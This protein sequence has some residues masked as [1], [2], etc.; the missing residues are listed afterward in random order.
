MSGISV[1]VVIDGIRF[2]APIEEGVP[3]RLGSGHGVDVHLPSG[4]YPEH[5]TVMIDGDDLT[6]QVGEHLMRGPIQDGAL[7]FESAAQLV[8]AA[9]APRSGRSVFDL[10]GLDEFVI[11]AH[12][13]A[14]VHSADPGLALSAVRSSEGGW[15]VSVTGPG[16]FVSN[17]HCPEGR[18]QLRNG[19]HLGAGVHDLVLFERE[20]HV[21]DAIVAGAALPRRGSSTTTPPA[22]YPDLRRSPRLI[23]RDPEE[24][25]TVNPPPAEEE[26][27]K[28]GQLAKLIIPPLLMVAVTAVMAVMRGNLLFVLASATT[29]VATLT[30]SLTGYIKE[31]RTSAEKREAADA[32]YREYLDRKA[33]EIHS[34]NERQRGGALYHF[35][36]IASLLTL[37]E[38]FSPRVFE[39]TALQFDFL[40]Y[41]LGLGTVKSTSQIDFPDQERTSKNSEL[42]ALVRDLADSSGDLTGMPI[43]ADLMHGPVG[44]VGPRRLVVEQ[45]QLLVNQLAVFHSYHDVQ[46]VMV[47]PEDELDDWSWMRW[48]RHSSLQEMNLRGFVYDQ[49]SRD[50]VLSSL[51]Q[52]L[53]ARQNALNE[54]RA[55]QSTSFSPH[56]V[57]VI[58]DEALV[59]DHVIMEFLRE[60][61]TSLGCSVVFVQETM[62]SLSD[63]ITTV[64]DVRDRDTAVLVLERGE[65]REARITLDHFPERFDKERLPRA[66]GARDHLQNLKSSIPDSV[67]FLEMYEVERFEDLGV[68]GRWAANSPHRTLGV[69]LGL[70]GA[71]DI[72]KLDLHEKA[73]GPHGLVAG[74]TGSGKSE[75]I[76]SYI[77][78]LAVN[79]HPHD[80][81]FLL[82]DYKGGGMANLFTDLPHLLGTITN[83][84]GAQSMRAL[85][86]INAELKR[87]QRLFSANNVNHINQY[88]KLYKSG[89]V[90]EPM[91]HLF[92]ISDEFA[93]L[94]SEQPEF[95][96]ELI[97]TARIGRSLGIHLILA[98]QKPSGV[99]NDQIWSNSKFK[100]A[101][102]VADRSDSMEII[103]TPD[104]AEIT[105]PGR[106]YLQVGNNEIYELFQSA[107]SGAD[108]EPE[109]EEN[110]QEDHTIYAINDLGQYQIL[111]EDLSGL[112]NAD[113]VKQIPSELEAVVRGIQE[114]AEASGVEP[115]PRPWL[116]PLD[117]RI[118][119][120]DLHMP[121]R[122]AAWGGPKQP[123]R[124]TIGRVDIPSMQAQETLRLDLSDDGHVLVYG[125]PGYG[126]STFLQTLVM[127]LARTHNPEHLHVYLLD[128]ATNGLLPLRRLPQVADTVTVDDTEK[129]VKFVGRIE[130]E[131]RRRKQL[132]SQFSVASLPM[133][134]RASGEVLPHV[135]VV[136][137]GFEGLKGSKAEE[138]VTNL[139][140]S[141]AREGAGLGM[142]LVMSAGRQASL[143]STLSS[144]FKL[145]VALKLNDDS[146]ARAIVGRTSLQIDDLAGRGMIK[147]D[148][149]EIF[150]TALPATGDDMLAI[151]DA[152]QAEAAQMSESWTGD[153]PIPIP[154]IPERLSL[155][156]LEMHP[157]TQALRT[158]GV[159]PVGL[160]FDRVRPAGL[161]PAK[162]RQV[163]VLC[164]DTE[165]VGTTLT[166]LWRTIGDAYPVGPYV[167]DDMTGALR[168]LSDLVRDTGVVGSQVEVLTAA[169]A[170][171][172]AR[173]QAFQ[174]ASNGPAAPTLADFGR[175]LPRA[176][177][178]VGDSSTIAG[179]LGRE[180]G[181]DLLRLLTDGPGYGMSLVF[182]GTL[183]TAGKG[184]DDVGKAVKKTSAGLVLGKIPDQSLLKGSNITF[185]EPALGENEA[186]LVA[187]G[188][189]TRVKMPVA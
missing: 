4:T 151:I 181:A 150:Q 102:K 135:V 6:L 173:R 184:Y 14:S 142:H 58:L 95:M 188:V 177:V 29:T 172:D 89:D 30:F 122:A 114:V 38:G 64:V 33:V 42:N 128:F 65:L 46:F 158:A 3:V 108:Y 123:M 91:P 24:R 73:H 59:L 26:E 71:G 85:V 69:P 18:Y 186:Y 133:Y 8:E 143:R 130:A 74:T 34:V 92:L 13:G 189:A 147:L 51:N 119:L 25:V 155:A 87:R 2:V 111:N 187:D 136:V 22:G 31:R 117:E 52:I 106:A 12:D 185:K 164:G 125:S 28:S 53:K 93:E 19:D 129:I 166:G 20:L 78:S 159:I 96:S 153:R 103:K 138:Q 149:P 57:V 124:P 180:H 167:L 179:D 168:G 83:L 15:S 40:C 23:Y 160:D 176:L 61:P 97:S 169:V 171:L 94:K 112:D 21:D 156:E 174:E 98:T 45:L 137:D 17:V 162:Y 77:L 55:G 70:R 120:P 113:E 131:V 11:G 63:S 90:S 175:S 140:Q 170:E 36:T 10:T 178:V 9:C 146:E 99:V 84:D 72:V 101:L 82:I 79:F 47:F 41:R 66:I 126:K 56:Y 110:N 68:Q 44:Y 154:V 27:K 118:V 182:G 80:V 157:D 121:V 183:A 109:K 104:A 75:I 145:Q 1:A 86:S 163:A 81:A 5:V 116:P 62:S 161:H 144:N 48:Y 88:Q 35:P 165:A 134:E 43:T 127:D 107:W 37:G 115:L 148:Q 141:V 49:R 39:K 50:Q 105:L 139:L 32:E 7:R 132:L 100:L 152:I 67:T 16:V 76:Q 60:D 54:A